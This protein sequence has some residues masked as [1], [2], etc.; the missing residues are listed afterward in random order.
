[1]RRTVLGTRTLA[2]SR[3]A[4]PGGTRRRSFSADR[5]RTVSGCHP[6]WTDVSGEARIDDPRD[7]KSRRSVAFAEREVRPPGVNGDAEDPDRRNSAVLPTR[8]SGAYLT[9]TRQSARGCGDR[10]DGRRPGRP[11]SDRVVAISS[12]EWVRKRSALA[13]WDGRRHAGLRWSIIVSWLYGAD[14]GLL[15]PIGRDAGLT[16]DRSRRGQRVRDVRAGAE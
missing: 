8:T 7:P 13:A 1:M 15:R 11:E 2:P 9:R 6:S 10:A 12:D 4:A 5:P 16:S 14:G 3:S